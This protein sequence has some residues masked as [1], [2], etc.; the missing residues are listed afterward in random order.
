MSINYNELRRKIESYFMSVTR[1]QLYRDCVDAGLR[2][3]SSVDFKIDEALVLSQ[4]ERTKS[5]ILVLDETVSVYTASYEELLRPGKF[6]ISKPILVRA[7]YVGKAEY[8]ESANMESNKIFAIGTSAN[9]LMHGE[10]YGYPI[11]V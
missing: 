9:S 7:D 3:Y 1:E 6:E 5:L 4:K 2:E 10:D 8:V 11:G